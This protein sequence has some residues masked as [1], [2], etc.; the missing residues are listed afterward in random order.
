MGVLITMRKLEISESQLGIVKLQAQKL[1]GLQAVLHG[2]DVL[3]AQKVHSMCLTFPLETLAVTHCQLSR[4][5]WEHLSQCLSISQ[6]KHLY[7]KGVR[8]TLTSF[9]YIKNCTA[10]ATLDKLLYHTAKLSNLNQEQYSIPQDI[11]LLRDS[12]H[13]LRLDQVHDAL[14]RIVQSSRLLLTQL[15]LFPD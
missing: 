5:D 6:V 8:L 12:V 13:P 14:M 7:L 3:L 1:Q 4:S 15:T 10:V 2:L 11:F 9:S